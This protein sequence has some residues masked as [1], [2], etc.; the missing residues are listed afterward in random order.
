MLT[1]ME[2][3][4]VNIATHSIMYGKGGI[5]MKRKFLGISSL[6]WIITI[7]IVL[8]FVSMFVCDIV[9]YIVMGALGLSLVFFL[10][11]LIAMWID[12]LIN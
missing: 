7:A 4:N 5:Y 6:A 1:I 8:L 11:Y 12:C 3:A 10:I 2:Y 9:F